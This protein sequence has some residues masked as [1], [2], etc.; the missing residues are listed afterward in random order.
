M[1]LKIIGRFRETVEG[2]R[3]RLVSQKEHRKRTVHFGWMK[4][5]VSKSQWD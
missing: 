4:A 2:D 3:L 5:R 1:I